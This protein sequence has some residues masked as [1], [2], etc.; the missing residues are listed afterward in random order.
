[1]TALE[2]NFASFTLWNYTADNTNTHG[3][4]WNDED[5]SLFSRD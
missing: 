3:D 4:Q 1:M 5:L 2:E